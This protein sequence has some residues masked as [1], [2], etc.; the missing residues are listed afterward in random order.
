MLRLTRKFHAVIY[1]DSESLRGMLQVVKDWVAW[2]EIDRE[3]L[4]ELIVRRGRLIGNKRLTEEALKQIFNVS[5]LDELI[6]A[7]M[8]GR[9]EWHK[10]DDK[11]KPVFRLHPPKGGFKGSIKKPYRSGGEL[12]YRGSGIN[13][14]LRRMI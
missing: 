7:L 2:G 6:D 10:L 9:I 11:V 14:L 3:T 13:E 8:Q 5:N 4:K 12:G 1:P